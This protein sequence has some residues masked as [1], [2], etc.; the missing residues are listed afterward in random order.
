MKKLQDR[1]QKTKDAVVKTRENYEM[2]LQDLNNY[3]AKYMEDMTEVFERCQRMEAQRLQCFKDTLFAVQKC[4]NVSQDPVLPQ[5]YEEF[6]HTVNNADH[7]KDLRWWANTHGVNMAMNW[8]TFEVSSGDFIYKFTSR[9]V[10]R[11]M[12]MSFVNPCELG[13]HGGVPRDRRRQDQSQGQQRRRRR[14]HHPH[15]PETRRR[16]FASNYQFI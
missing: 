7:E 3:N 8:P 6:Y 9:D 2:C 15:Q 12:S 11:C 4:L 10:I 1:V 5:I 16:R 14:Q 13:V